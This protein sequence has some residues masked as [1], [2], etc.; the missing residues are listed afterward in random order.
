MRKESK[1]A[2]LV[3]GYFFLINDGSGFKSLPHLKHIT[4]KINVSLTPLCL[5]LQ[6]HNDSIYSHRDVVLSPDDV[7][8]VKC[9]EITHRVCEIEV[10]VAY[11]V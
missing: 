5:P 3:I 2:T 7:E 8:C 11:M 4:D 1:N 6:N 10:D 9:D